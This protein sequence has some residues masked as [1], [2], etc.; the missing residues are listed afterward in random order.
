[1]I[2]AGKS[3][4]VCWVPG[5]TGLPSKESTDAAEHKA[6]LQQDEISER[7][8]GSDVC[9]HLHFDLFAFLQDEWTTHRMEYCGH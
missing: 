6:A 7:A 5:H 2:K 4:V 9:V 1:M 8:L 3:V